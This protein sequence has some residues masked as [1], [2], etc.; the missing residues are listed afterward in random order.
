MINGKCKYIEYMIINKN[1]KY[2]SN[3]F[4]HTNSWQVY[5]LH[6]F[7]SDWLFRCLPSVE[8]NHSIFYYM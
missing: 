4:T 3:A 1:C 5:S 2:I 7:R 8:W 6:C